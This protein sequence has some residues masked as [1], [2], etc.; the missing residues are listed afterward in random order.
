MV[1]I[2]INAE[3]REKGGKG[4]ARSARRAGKVPGVIYGGGK[5]PAMINVNANELLKRLR[6][7]RFLSTLITVNHGDQKDVVLC[8]EVQRNVI[9]GLPIHVDFM[10]VSRRQKVEVFVP[11]EFLNEE[12]CKGIRK[13]GTLVVVRPEVELR[14]PATHIPE[15]ISIDLTNY[16]FG[17]VIHISDFEL[18]EDAE[19][20]I[21]DRDF[22]IANIS[23]PGGGAAA[24]EAEGEAEA[25]AEAGGE[26]AEKEG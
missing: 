10:R 3:T 24:E 1:D 2:V 23:A 22:V 17:D 18:P 14:V 21:E 25:E 8:R 26:E 12:E 9:N 15:K 4:A 13:G 5:A 6:A 11:V 19:P 16:D 20:V 7:G